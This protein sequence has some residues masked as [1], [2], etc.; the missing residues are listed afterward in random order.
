MVVQ[1]LSKIVRLYYSKF[2]KKFQEIF[3]NINNLY[4]ICI[5]ER[6]MTFEIVIYFIVSTKQRW[7]N[8][9]DMMEN[10]GIIQ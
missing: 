4:K 5:I 6:L 10:I 2:C 7:E 1:K 9:V 3:L 8:D